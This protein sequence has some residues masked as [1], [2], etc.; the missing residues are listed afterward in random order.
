MRSYVIT[1]FNG[2]VDREKIESDLELLF[3]LFKNTNQTFSVYS[4]DATDLTGEYKG[5]KLTQKQ[6]QKLEKENVESGFAWK[7]RDQKGRAV[8]V[9]GAGY[10][11]SNWLR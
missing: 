6:Y 5:K 9:D 7:S 10:L 1:I 8:Y 3:R 2:A 11:S 4:S